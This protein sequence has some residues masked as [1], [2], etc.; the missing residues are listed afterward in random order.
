MTIKEVI[1]GCLRCKSNC[2]RRLSEWFWY[3]PLPVSVEKFSLDTFRITI[4]RNAFGRT[5]NLNVKW[6]KKININCIFYIMSP[7]KKLGYDSQIHISIFLLLRKH[8]LRASKQWFWINALHLPKLSTQ[9][10]W[11]FM[12]INEI[13]TILEELHTYFTCMNLSDLL[14]RMR[15]TNWQ[16]KFFHCKEKK[17][18]EPSVYSK[19]V[20][21]I[22]CTWANDGFFLKMDRS[23]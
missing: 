16:M 20:N 17:T 12:Q 2:G 10:T 23:L 14:N 4:G 7:N 15:L 6:G 21:V 22:F 13:L 11:H 8:L 5:W 1:S 3:A 19:N 9:N 18:N